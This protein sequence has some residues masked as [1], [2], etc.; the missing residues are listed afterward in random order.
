MNVNVVN[1]I[2][3]F[4]LVFTKVEFKTNQNSI[5][6]GSGFSYPTWKHDFTEPIME[7]K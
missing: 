7:P 5:K 1:E 4:I 2:M 6:K 3:Y